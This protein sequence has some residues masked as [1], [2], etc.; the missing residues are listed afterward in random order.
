MTV[1]TGPNGAGKSNLV[2]ALTFLS[3][4]LAYDLEI[5]VAR[6][7]GYENIAFRG[8]DKNPEPVGCSFD[9]EFTLSEV[10]RWSRRYRARHSADALSDTL[11]SMTYNFAID[12]PE[13]ADPSE[14]R[15]TDENF[16]LRDDEGL[17]IRLKHSAGNPPSFWRSKRM[18]GPRASLYH[19]LYPLSDNDYIRFAK[20]EIDEATLLVSTLAFSGTMMDVITRPLGQAELSNHRWPF[21]ASAW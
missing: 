16:E 6:A 1:I 11:I 5:A 3:E 19:A 13:G 10:P 20:S 14:F 4:C 17:I 18:K 21:A 2:E 15:I 12:H 8:V 9:A 7:G